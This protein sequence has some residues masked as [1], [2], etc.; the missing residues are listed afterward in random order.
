MSRQL[1]VLS[2]MRDGASDYDESGHGGLADDMRKAAEI[3]AELIDCV[4]D[5]QSLLAEIDSAVRSEH[6]KNGHPQSK[7]VV[8]IINDRLSASIARVQGGVA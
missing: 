8:G 2:V 4:G 6:A 5:A 1:G 3:V 7:S